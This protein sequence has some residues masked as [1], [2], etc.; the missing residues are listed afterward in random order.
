MIEDLNLKNVNTIKK[1]APG[2][3]LAD[4]G[5]R[6]SIQVTSDNTSD[7]IKHTIAE[8]FLNKS[9]EKYDRLIILI[10]TNKK[11]YSTVFDTDGKFSFDKNK[12]I[13]DV[14]DLIK[15]VNALS[16]KYEVTLTNL[17]SEINKVENNANTQINVIYSFIENEQI[18]KKITLNLKTEGTTSSKEIKNSIILTQ[19]TNQGETKCIV[20][21]LLKFTEVSNL[22][23][24]NIENCLFLDELPE[25]ER[26]TTLD[27]LKNKIINIYTSKK[28]N[29]NFI[30]TNTYSAIVDT[31][32]PNVTREEAKNAL[33][34]KVSSMMGEALD[35]DQEFTIQNLVDL[36]IDG[37]KV[38]ST[39]TESSAVIVVDVYTFNIDKNFLLTD[40]E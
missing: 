35:K 5:N 11:R 31:L 24:I 36:K 23:E 16:E 17:D 39:V 30:D 4:E 25:E 20:D 9:Y 28:E 6:I 22:E 27:D 34:N 26:N 8:F 10:L 29:L 40:V 7:K 19:S 18:N 32:I 1:N 33:I 37:Y 2:I 21:N 13:W 38:T 12:D 15:K 3:D 14:N